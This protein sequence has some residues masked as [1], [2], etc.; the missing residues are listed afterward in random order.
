M[1]LVL[2]RQMKGEVSVWPSPIFGGIQ[3]EKRQ[4][5]ISTNF[6]SSI[7]ENIF[8]DTGLFSKQAVD[9]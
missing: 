3:L 9:L 6:L 2:R 8:S 7:N 4:M 5:D 1:N